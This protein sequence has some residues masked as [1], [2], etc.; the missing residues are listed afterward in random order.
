MSIQCALIKILDKLESSLQIFQHLV[1]VNFCFNFNFIPDSNFNYFSN[2]NL[3]PLS[4]LPLQRS[5]FIAEIK[6]SVK[7]K[8][9]TYSFA[10]IH[11]NWSTIDIDYILV[12]KL[13]RFL[14]IQRF[15]YDML[16][17]G[18]LGPS[19]FMLTENRLFNNFALTKTFKLVLTRKLFHK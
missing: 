2:F 9:C 18:D 7:K 12:K 14:F 19:I 6:I 10:E 4:S 1:I 8:R 3:C 5:N 13:Q 11:Q 15:K 17:L 16:A